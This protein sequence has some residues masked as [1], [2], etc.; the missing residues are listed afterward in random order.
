MYLLAKEVHVENQV[1]KYNFREYVSKELG[2]KQ[3][4]F[5]YLKWLSNKP[6]FLKKHHF[7]IKNQHFDT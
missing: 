7:L 6:Y 1:K 3:N 5:F 2:F 4:K